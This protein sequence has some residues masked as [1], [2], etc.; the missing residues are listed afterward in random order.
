MYV[1]NVVY[2]DE[3]V[4]FILSVIWLNDVIKVLIIV[5]ELSII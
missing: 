2:F 5:Y 4:W 3:R 1:E